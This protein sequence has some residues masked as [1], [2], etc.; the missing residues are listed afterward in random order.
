[1]KRP[2]DEAYFSPLSRRSGK[3]SLRAAQID[4]SKRGSTRSLQNEDDEYEYEEDEDDEM[5][6]AIAV[7]VSH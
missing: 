4:I 5:V 7:D 1:L 6:Y 2:E 3:R